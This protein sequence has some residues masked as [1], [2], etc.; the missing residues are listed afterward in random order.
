MDITVGDHFLGAW[1]NKRS[2]KHVSDFGRL[3]SYG[4]LR[5][6]IESKDCLKI[7]GTK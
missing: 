7:N 2:C 3:R 5:L 6:K 1:E 4:R